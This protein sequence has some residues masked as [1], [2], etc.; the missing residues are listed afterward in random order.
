MS[1]AARA[2]GLFNSP[3]SATNGTDEQWTLLAA[4]PEGKPHNRFL[5]SHTEQ[6]I[7]L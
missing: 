4:R 6:Q 1:R 3:K 7:K 2:G 5:S